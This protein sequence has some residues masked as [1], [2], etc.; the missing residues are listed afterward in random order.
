M[1]SCALVQLCSGFNDNHSSIVTLSVLSADAPEFLLHDLLGLDG[2]L[3]YGLF[4]VHNV[5]R[6]LSRLFLPLSVAEHG[7]QLQLEWNF[8]GDHGLILCACPL[9]EC[10]HDVGRVRLHHSNV[11]IVAL[12]VDEQVA[13]CINTDHLWGPEKVL[14]LGSIFKSSLPAYPSKRIHILLINLDSSDAVIVFV[15]DIGNSRVN[16]RVV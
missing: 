10:V 13:F 2:C 15:G 16:I 1:L 12:I 5:L 8:R 14:T 7:S 3:F 11:A 6:W 4:Q 9:N